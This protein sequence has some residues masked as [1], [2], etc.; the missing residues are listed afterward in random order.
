MS[1][2]WLSASVPFLVAVVVGCEG[3][4]WLGRDSGTTLVADSPFGA[5]VA[6][7]PQSRPAFS[8]GP[9]STAAA[10]RVD[11]LGRQILVANPQIGAKPLFSTI[12]T[13]QPALF[14]KGTAEILITEGLVKQCA[15]DGQLAALLCHELGEMV[16]ER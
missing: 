3:L 2:V 10:A 14:H 6:S 13:P 1:R 8:P 15:S 4:G 9:V 5:P 16:S 7:A 12:G 11:T